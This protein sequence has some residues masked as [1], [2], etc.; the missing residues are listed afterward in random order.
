MDAE[1][2]FDRVDW[3]FMQ[4]TLR[5]NG[6]GL[7]MLRWILSLTELQSEFFDI[8]DGMK[9]G[10]PFSLVIFILTL[11]PFLCSIR[12]TPDG[13]IKPWAIIKLQVL[14]MI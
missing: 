5:H 14:L 1:K 4:A 10:C 2:T 13:L 6:L 9:Q 7:H 12:G 8:S 3:I 11:E